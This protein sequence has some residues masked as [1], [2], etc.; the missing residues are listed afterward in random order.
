MNQ[1]SSTALFYKIINN[2]H[3]LYNCECRNMLTGHTNN[4][5]TI[6]IEL[7]RTFKFENSDTL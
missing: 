7:M 3:Q 1:K 4:L 5:V 6:A 2:L